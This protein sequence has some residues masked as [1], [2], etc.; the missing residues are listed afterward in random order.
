[1]D[2]EG[3]KGDKK[4]FYFHHNR[5]D[6]KDKFFLGHKISANGIQEGEQAL[7]I[8]ANHP[9]TAHFISYKLAQYFVA[10]KPPSVLIERLEQEFISSHGNIKAIMDVLIHSPEFNSPEY[11]K[12]KL[13]T[14]YQ[15]LISLVRMGEISQPNLKQIRG[16]LEQLSM[17]L[18][19]CVIPTG[20]SNTQ[21][22]WLNPQAVLL[23][24]SFATDIANGVLNRD[25]EIS[26]QQLDKNLGDLSPKT[27]QAIA[28]SPSELHAALMMGSPEAMYR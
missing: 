7:D 5:H 23:R 2:H 8:L 15:Y 28:Q 1:M 3:N 19:H 24:T 16:M 21:S 27:K 4:G 9:A 20:Y 25:Y 18:F 12:Q 13:K 17:P 14:P 6:R 10:D 22:A 11:Y 26:Q